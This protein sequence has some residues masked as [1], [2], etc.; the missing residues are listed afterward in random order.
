MDRYAAENTQ[1]VLVVVQGDDLVSVAKPSRKTPRP[2]RNGCRSK[3]AL[4][5][6]ETA[7]SKTHFVS[8]LWT[9]PCRRDS[10]SASNHVLVSDNLENQGLAGTF[11]YQ[12]RGRLSSTFRNKMPQRSL[13]LCLV[14]TDCRILSSICGAMEFSRSRV[15]NHCF[16]ITRFLPLP[17]CP[18]LLP[19]FG[20][21]PA[22]DR[23]PQPQDC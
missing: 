4:R 17:S 3:M 19:Q 21:A 13:S 12:N 7:L 1:T 15:K 2:I 8:G 23:T 9:I 18:H 6:T 16:S 10:S 20:P 22:K 11:V 5:L 14:R